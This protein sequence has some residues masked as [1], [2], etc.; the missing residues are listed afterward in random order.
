MRQIAKYLVAST[1]PE[2]RYSTKV[3]VA[4]KPIKNAMPYM[5]AETNLAVLYGSL[6]ELESMIIVPL[7][8]II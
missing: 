1:E 8:V 6:F 2:I 4:Y 7:E 5:N 3:E